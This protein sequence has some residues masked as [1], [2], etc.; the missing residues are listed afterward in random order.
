MPFSTRSTFL[1][2]RVVYSDHWKRD[3]FSIPLKSAKNPYPVFKC[4]GVAVCHFI[5]QR[6]AFGT[7]RRLGVPIHYGFRFATVLTC[8]YSIFAHTLQ[9]E[10]KIEACMGNPACPVHL[11]ALSIA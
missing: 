2:K 4:L 1:F 8:V 3:K 10:P 5:F 9:Y 6:F 7:V 11:S